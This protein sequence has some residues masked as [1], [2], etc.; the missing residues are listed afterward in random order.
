MLVHSSEVGLKVLRVGG[1]V[2]GKRGR[3]H[4]RSCSTVRENQNVFVTRA[5][6]GMYTSITL[7]TREVGWGC[8]CTT[9]LV[10]TCNQTSRTSG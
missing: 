3:V 10:G 6:W 2:E 8:V 4:T 1:R 7:D 5:A 9:K